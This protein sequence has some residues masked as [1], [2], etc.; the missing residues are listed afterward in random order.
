MY[1]SED[2]FYV[3][4]L[5][6]SLNC[7]LHCKLNF[8]VLLHFFFRKVHHIRV[9]TFVPKCVEGCCPFFSHLTLH[10]HF[11]DWVIP[12]FSPQSCQGL[13]TFQAAFCHH[14][15]HTYSYLITMDINSYHPQACYS[16]RFS[17]TFA[18][19]GLFALYS[20]CVVFPSFFPHGMKFIL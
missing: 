18:Q 7:Q 17:V 14:V 15:L 13:L 10:S 1:Y 2:C 20:L 8:G 4:I 11:S 12:G 5:Y 6:L 9:I 3:Y 16:I 19:L